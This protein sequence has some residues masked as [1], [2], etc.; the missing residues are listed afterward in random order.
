MMLHL[1]REDLKMRT[2]VTIDDD[3]L[4]NAQKSSGIKEKSALVSEALRGMIQR[5][6]YRRLA[7]LGGSEPGLKA[8]PRRRQKP[9]R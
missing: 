5:E 1:M 2:T 6:A 9:A 4:A 8:P 7:L 3:L